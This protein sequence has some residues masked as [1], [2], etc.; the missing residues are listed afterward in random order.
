[1]LCCR[2]IL[3]LCLVSSPIIDRDDPSLSL[4]LS[5]MMLMVP[6]ASCMSTYPTN[7]ALLINFR[8]SSDTEILLL[9]IDWARKSAPKCAKTCVRCLCVPT[10]LPFCMPPLVVGHLSFLPPSF[11]H[12]WIWM[13]NQIMRSAAL[14]STTTP[15]RRGL[16]TGLFLLLLLLQKLVP[17]T[18]S[19]S[20]LI[21]VE[22]SWEKLRRVAKS[23]ELRCLMPNSISNNYSQVSI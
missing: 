8:P 21:K 14:F 17:T 16:S 20:P 9:S 13:G 11:H 1:M 12:D 22:E 5:F 19:Y 10:K 15:G 3:R 6:E 18:K 2:H 4:F 7:N 23:W